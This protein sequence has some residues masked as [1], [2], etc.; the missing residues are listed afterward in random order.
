[1]RADVTANGR[2]VLTSFSSWIF[3]TQFAP[4][5]EWHEYFHLTHSDIGW[6]V[7]GT[8]RVEVTLT[9]EIG[10]PGCP[11]ARVGHTTNA[12]CLDLSTSSWERMC[13]AVQ[14]EPGVTGTMPLVELSVI[15]WP[16]EQP[17]P[18]RSSAHR[19]KAF[20]KELSST[21]FG[22]INVSE[23]HTEQ[24]QVEVEEW[25]IRI[26]HTTCSGVLSPMSRL[27][28]PP[29]VLQRMGIPPNSTHMCFAYPDINGI[30]KITQLSGQCDEGIEQ[31]VQHGAFCYFHEVLPEI[32]YMGSSIQALE[33]FLKNE[34]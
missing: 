31:M 2:H 15:S 33:N 17:R 34:S 19:H 9:L 8:P 10:R 22:V 28:L 6:T 1:M 18:T 21:G 24:I 11:N 14:P 23:E 13:K 5:P 27:T 26:E 4:N 32:D 25:S 20:M 29:A 30:D 16:P 3:I 7:H 12:H